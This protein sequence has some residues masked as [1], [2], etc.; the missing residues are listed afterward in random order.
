MKI[1]EAAKQL[2]TSAWTLRYY[3]EIGVLAPVTR[4]SGMR[5]YQSADLARIREILD[6]RACGVTLEEIKRFLRLETTANSA[7]AQR[8]LLTGQADELRTQITELEA[9][10]DRLETKIDTLPT[11]ELIS[12]GTN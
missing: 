3:E 7:A 10:L 5:D 12:N 1:N 9:T 4:I 6:L 11:K 2:H 8:T